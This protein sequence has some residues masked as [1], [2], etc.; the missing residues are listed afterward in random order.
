MDAG[1]AG[2]GCDLAF[3]ALCGAWMGDA[4]A[5]RCVTAGDAGRGR[6]GAG[7]R[8]GRIAGETEYRLRARAAARSG[9]VGVSPGTG[10]AGED[11]SALERAGCGDDSGDHRGEP[12]SAG[13]GRDG[14]SRRAGVAQGGSAEF[15]RA[16]T[17]RTADGDGAAGTRVC[18]GT[19]RVG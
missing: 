10:F 11:A 1:V 7:C 8:V 3:A 9:G 18:D 6:D 16:G 12:A 19:V 14:G 2:R 17:A 5:Q 15:L 4:A 13:G